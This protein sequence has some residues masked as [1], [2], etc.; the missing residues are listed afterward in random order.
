MA[1]VFKYDGHELDIDDV[2]L[3]VYVEIETAT[4][5]PWYRLV[6]NPMRFAAAG[7]ELAKACAKQVG[8]DLPE[9]TPR[10]FAEVFDVRQDQEN[11][12]TE[13][14]EGIPDPKAEASEAETT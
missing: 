8:V 4:G 5:T 11:R 12:P 9:L 7:Q 1:I 10:T 14:E 6:T 3:S 2:P 13:Y